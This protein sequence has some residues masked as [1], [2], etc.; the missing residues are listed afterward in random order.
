MGGTT[1]KCAAHGKQ[2]EIPHGVDG[3]TIAAFGFSC[4]DF[5]L[6]NNAAPQKSC[7]IQK[8]LGSSGRTARDLLTF[9]EK[10][11]MPIIVVENVEE[12]LSDS[13]GQL[14]YFQQVLLDIG[15]KSKPMVM[16]TVDYL[17]PQDRKRAYII[18]LHQH[19]VTLEDGQ[20]VD[21]I[22]DNI[23]STAARLASN[24]VFSLDDIC[25][26]DTDPRVIAGLKRRQDATENQKDHVKW[27]GLH[28]EFL[29]Q[30]GLTKSD[31][32]GKPQTRASP[33]FQCLPEREQD[34]VGYWENRPDAFAVDTSQTIN[35][36]P[37]SR[38][39]IMS[40]LMPEGHYYLFSRQ[41][42]LLGFECLKLQGCTPF[43]IDLSYRPPRILSFSR[44]QGAGYMMMSSAGHTH[45]AVLHDSDGLLP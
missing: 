45:S 26:S 6:Q 35:R 2:C 37:L 22:L 40:S 32:V 34:I 14:Q 28:F 38:N 21:G 25:L 30:Q 27:P 18:G 9:L 36:A 23:V 42:P 8:G 43:E 3:P 39:S 19:M 7:M 10:H 16:R 17:L 33:W 41:R 31:V 12:F 13:H 15:Y 5:S 11:P 24:Q 29:Q 1:A 44:G 20:T 4:K